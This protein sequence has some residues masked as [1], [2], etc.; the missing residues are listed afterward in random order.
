MKLHQR[1][2]NPLN[3]QPLLPDHAKH[4]L[5]IE[6][7]PSPREHPLVIEVGGNSSHSSIAQEYGQ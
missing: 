5:R 7:F 6:R 3:L 1:I 2:S 4:Q